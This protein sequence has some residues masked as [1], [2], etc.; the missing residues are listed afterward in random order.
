LGQEQDGVGTGTI[1]FFIRNPLSLEAENRQKQY[2][3]KEVTMSKQKIYCPHC[4]GSGKESKQNSSADIILFHKPRV[5]RVSCS[6]CNGKG[7]VYSG[8]STG[9]VI[10]GATFGALMGAALG[11]VGAVGGA[12]VGG[13]VGKI[14]GW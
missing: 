12:I 2:R 13:I 11:P 14:K 6:G 10:K 8:S 9:D 1:N 7:W 4:N 3:W 5:E